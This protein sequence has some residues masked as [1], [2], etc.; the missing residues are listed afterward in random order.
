MASIYAKLRGDQQ[1]APDLTESLG[2]QLQR[3][4][5][6]FRWGDIEEAE[7]RRESLAL[8][9]QLS[10]L[11]PTP[12]H[13]TAK[14]ERS[15]DLIGNL[16]KLW[17]HPGVSHDKRKELVQEVFEVILLGTEGLIAVKA[18]ET[19]LPLLAAIRNRCRLWSGREDLNLR[20]QRPKRCALFNRFQLT[21][22]PARYSLSLTQ[23]VGAEK[24]AEMVKE[25]KR[26]TCCHCDCQCGLLVDVEEGQLARIRGNP[27]H[28]VSRGYICPRGK[29]AIE[30]FYHP[31]RLR[32]PM[33]RAGDRGQGRWEPI[34]WDQALDEIA[35]K[36]ASVK[37][38]HG[39]EAV[40]H[41]RG[42]F[43]GPDAGMGV[44]FFNLFGSPNVIGVG[45]N[46]A[47]P[48]MEAEALTYGMGPT[49]W[50]APVPGKTRCMVL[51]GHRRAASGPASWLRFREAQKAGASLIVIDPRET[52]EAGKADLWLQL[53]PGSDGALALGWLHVIITEGL[54]DRDFVS[55]W[56][57]GFDRLAEQVLAW[58]PERVA[59][60]TWVPAELIRQAAR[61]Y[62]QQ[63]PNIIYWGLGAAQTGLNAVQAE[64]AK[65]ALRAITGGLDVEGGTRLG[66]PP[67]RIL[68]RVDLELNEEI[69]PGQ[70]AKLLGADRFKL[71]WPGY[72][73]LSQ[74]QERIWNRK[75]TLSSVW[76]CQ[77]HAP[78]LWRAILEERPY[79]IKAL[80][81]NYN[82]IMGANANASLVYRA[83]KSPKLELITVMEQFMT[84]TAELADYV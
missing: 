32:H 35:S 78:T 36:L 22:G 23:A 34:P 48:A 69:S 80:V 67:D 7:Y 84:P 73:M 1:P 27:D 24:G 20:P 75:Y 83:L 31:T 81:V 13:N 51:W 71:P 62:A 21:S 15:A 49:Y 77:A 2:K 44:R 47:G 16:G 26:V 74:A 59:R 12:T 63:T 9:V 14:L 60:M 42:T 28:I 29:A 54:Y 70:R 68:T 3:L 10:R 46:C 76:A 57:V 66:G 38:E 79:P 53:R 41:A 65:A 18:R 8:K 72:A 43:H 56:T 58:P 82:N 39:A 55:R 64:L 50:G 30:Y 17:T 4:K 19:Y 5:M 11:Q 61:I 52:E 6:L 45:T 37:E 33:K 25:T 40:A